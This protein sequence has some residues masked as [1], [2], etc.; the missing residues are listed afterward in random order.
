M[1][2]VRER[3]GSTSLVRWLHVIAGIVWIGTS[4][5]FVALD[6]HL[7]PPAR[8]ARRR[9]RRRRRVVGDPRRRL[10]PD[11]EVPRR[12]AAAAGAAALVQVGGVHDLAV[13]LRAA[14]RPLLLRRATRTSID[15]AVADLEHVA[16]DRRSASALLVRRLARL[17]RALPPARRPSSCWP[18]AIVGARRRSRRAAARELLRAARRVPPGRRDA[19]D[20]HGRERLLRDHPGALG[21]DPGEGGGPRARPAAG[22]RAAS[23]ARCTTTT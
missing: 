13:G 15:P 12:A 3:A 8:G 23:S 16:G 21:A 20:D 17:R 19:R 6:N 18:R 1:R 5:Y 9:A 2:S 22:T 14:R 11:R 4:F 7:R 10:L